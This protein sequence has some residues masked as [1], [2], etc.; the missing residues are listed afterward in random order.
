MHLCRSALLACVLLA[1][2]PAAASAADVSITGATL[3]F[4]AAD[5]ENNVVTVSFVP[6]TYTLTDSVATVATS[7]A[8]SS[9]PDPHTVTCPSAGITA[10]TIDGRDLDDVINVGAGTVATTITGGAGDDALTGG[11]AADTLNGGPDADRLDGGAANDTLNGD[12]GD[13][14]FLGGVGNDVFNGGIG[15]DVA[16]YTGRVSPVIVTIDGT[17][18]DGGPGETD[19][20]KTDVENV[21]GGDGNDAL[22]GSSA[23]NVLTG[24]PGQDSLDGDTGNDVLDGGVGADVFT[25][26]AGT[27]TVTYANRVAQV[28]VTLD[29]LP[30]DGVAGENDELRT[31]IEAVVGGA[32]DDVLTGSPLADTLSGGPGADVLHGEG[33]ADTLS[34]D[35]GDDTLEGGAGGDVHNGGTGF[36]TADYSART[37]PVTADL[38]GAADDGETAE[39][40]N[41]RPDVERLLGGAGDDTLTG[42]N[43]ANVL[44]GGVGN[45]ILDGGRSADTLL[46]GSG[47]DAVTYAARTLALVADLDGVADDGEPGEADRIDVDVENLTGGSANDR[48]TGSAGSNILNGGSGNDILDGGLGPDLVIGGAG[49]DTAD[50][51]ARATTVVA[52]PDGAADDGEA[53]ETD[54]VETDVENLLG[55]SADDVL[56]GS[57]AANVLVGGLGNDVLDA[58]QG[59]DDLD[60]GDGNDDLTGGSGVDQLRGGPGADRISARDGAADTVK[61]AG[62]TDTATLDAI[63]DPGTECETTSLPPTGTTGPTGPAGPAGPAGPSGPAG[64]TGKTGPA[65]PAGRDAVV[66]C[67]PA[68]GKGKAAKVTVTCTVKLATAS[69]TRVRAV[70]KRAGHVVAVARGARR[71]GAVRLRLGDAKLA[72]GRYDVVLVYTVDGHRTKVKQRIRVA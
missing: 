68:K 17:G 3:S 71:G 35:D 12:A 40:D 52:D 28:V 64:P 29:G 66:T 70:F 1:L 42:N 24:G 63:D 65:G 60:G 18:N 58:L 10:I 55:G 49:A 67:K 72:R 53:G 62:G 44:D 43:A 5:G 13:D 38:D 56:T 22:V 32:G 47:V 14:T 48:L 37:E 25:G 69:A 19:N 2:A 57:S 27:D 26:G 21:I 15:T 11:S 8:C 4:A 33:A 30:G 23:V 41:V 59:D 51:S 45:D 20:V 9:T 31:D 61:C 6:G 54:T 34:G 36:D 50:Y 7:G 46:G 16:D 39:A